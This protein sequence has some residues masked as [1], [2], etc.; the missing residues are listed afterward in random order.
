MSIV[1]SAT[2]TSVRGVELL[3]HFYRALHAEKKGW[4]RGSK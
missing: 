3:K 2:G 4:G 1:N